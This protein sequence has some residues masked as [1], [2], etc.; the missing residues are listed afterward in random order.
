MNLVEKFGYWKDTA[1]MLK[2]D[3]VKSYTLLFLQM[4]NVTER[5]I[6]NFD[7]YLDIKIPNIYDDK[8]I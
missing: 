7:R 4:W 6:G 3:A 5:T 1:V 8:V 2:G